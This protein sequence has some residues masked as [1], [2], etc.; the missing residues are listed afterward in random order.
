MGLKS[1]IRNKLVEKNDEKVEFDEEPEGQEKLNVRIDHLTSTEDVERIAKLVKEGNIM[2]LK[3]KDLQQ[4]DLGLLQTTIQ[5][6]KRVCTQS[7][8]DVVGL[9]DGYLVVTPGFAKVER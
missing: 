4:R 9:E 7:G 8:W 1:W 2:F 5:K 6:L 3:I